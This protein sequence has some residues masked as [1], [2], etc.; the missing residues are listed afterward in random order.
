MRA[1]MPDFRRPRR[2]YTLLRRHKL[3]LQRSIR[4]HRAPLCTCNQAACAYTIIAI[5]CVLFLA[6]IPLVVLVQQHFSQN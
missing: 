5:A 2:V 1:H 3:Q 4:E 6:S